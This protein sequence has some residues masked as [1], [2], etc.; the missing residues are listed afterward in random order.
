MCRQTMLVECY[1]ITTIPSE[2]IKH[3]I[4]GYILPTFHLDVHEIKGL[5]PDT[6]PIVHE[7]QGE[8]VYRGLSMGTKRQ[9]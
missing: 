1:V 6:C 7:S 4:G 5:Q 9:K 3:V 8:I 2:Y